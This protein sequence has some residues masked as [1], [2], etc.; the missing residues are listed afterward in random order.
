M[1]AGSIVPKQCF[2]ADI[3]GVPTDFAIME[4]DQ[5]MVVATQMGKLGTLLQARQDSLTQTYSV[6]VL[7]GR[8]NDPLLEVLARQLIEKLAMARCPK[9]LTIWLGLKD[10]SN[11]DAIKGIIAAVSDKRPWK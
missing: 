6:E 4:F 1:E 10:P 11:P 7:L 2:S 8:R 3:L 9:N 5:I